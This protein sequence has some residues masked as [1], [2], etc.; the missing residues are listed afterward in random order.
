MKFSTPEEKILIRCWPFSIFC[1]LDYLVWRNESEYDV[2][3]VHRTKPNLWSAIIIIVAIKYKWITETGAR[4][5]P[6]RIKCA[7]DMLTQWSNL[8]IKNKQN[9][10]PVNGAPF[11][12]SEH[13]S[14]ECAAPK[15]CW[16][17]L[18]NPT[19]INRSIQIQTPQ[20]IQTQKKKNTRQN[21]SCTHRLYNIMT[22]TC[23]S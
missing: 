21:K 2:P 9:V 17:Q 11:D 14:M 6:G 5:S 23:S 4:F 16:T 12:C 20:T 22:V 18:N 1:S 7:N 3:T 8:E 13:H 15:I 19:A 10:S